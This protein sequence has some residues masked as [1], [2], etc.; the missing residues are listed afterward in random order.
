MYICSCNL[1]T[2]L[3]FVKGTIKSY[4]LGYAKFTFSCAKMLCPPDHLQ[5]LCFFA[6]CDPTHSVQ[7][8]AFQNWANGKGLVILVLTY[9]TC[10]SNR[11]YVACLRNQY[12]YC[13]SC[14]YVGLPWGYNWHVTL[15]IIYIIVSLYVVYVYQ[16]SMY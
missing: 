1:L 7:I 10:F 11:R 12:S 9:W 14:I 16:N 8:A 2:N 5:R 13:Y 3:I 15:A 6:L 4:H